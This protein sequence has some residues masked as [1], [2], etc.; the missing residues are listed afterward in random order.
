MPFQTFNDR[1]QFNY[2]ALKPPIKHMQNTNTDQTK[3]RIAVKGKS[4]VATTN[5]LHTNTSI[6]NLRADLWS[7]EPPADDRQPADLGGGPHGTAAAGGV[8]R[9]GHQ[10]TS[11]L[12]DG[13]RPD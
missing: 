10:E 12:G 2:D 6:I 9:P 3:Q 13:P 11:L 8:R 7:S 4:T 1:M 5:H